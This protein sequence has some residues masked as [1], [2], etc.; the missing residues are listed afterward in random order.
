MYW[1]NPVLNLIKVC[2]CSK[3]FE[4]AEIWTHRLW[5]TTGVCN[6]VEYEVDVHVTVH[7]DKFL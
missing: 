4:W 2:Y 6:H 5:W 7:R 1:D 3:Y